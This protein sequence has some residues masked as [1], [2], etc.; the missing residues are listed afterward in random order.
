MNVV[1]KTIKRLVKGNSRALGKVA[2]SK[3][4]TVNFHKT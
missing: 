1:P 4:K 3:R 2:I